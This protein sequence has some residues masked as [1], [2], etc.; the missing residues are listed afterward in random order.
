VRSHHRV[1]V[2][3]SGV[4]GEMMSRRAEMTDEPDIADKLGALNTFGT[5]FQLGIVILPG[6]GS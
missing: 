6:T 1:A 4:G 3:M 2:E 5:R